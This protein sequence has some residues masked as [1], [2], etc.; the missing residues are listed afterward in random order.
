MSIRSG[1]QALAAVALALTAVAC[2]LTGTPTAAPVPSTEAPPEAA[3]PTAMVISTPAAEPLVVTHDGS[4]FQIYGLDGS[5]RE[6][7][8]AEGLSYARPNTAQVIG[9]AIYYVAGGGGV[10]GEIVRRVT[11]G[12]T[13]DLEFT[14]S[15][16]PSGLAF[17]VSADGGRIAWSQTNWASGPPF[18]QLWMAGIDG[19]NPVLVAQT[20]AADDIAEFFVL[21][22]VLWLDDGDLVYAWQVSGIGGYILYFGW[23]SLY[24][25]EA[26]GAVTT[27]LA[28]VEPDVTAPCW[29]DVTP[30]G[31]FALGAC[32]DAH[33]IVERDTASGLET[34]FPPLPE[35]G[36]AGAAEYAPSPGRLAYGIARGDPD[37]EAGQLVLVGGPG[38]GPTPL[39]AVAPGAFS[40]IEWIDEA[41]LVA[42][43]WLGEGP[44][45]S[46]VD[47]IGIDGSRRP[48]GPGSLIGL[49]TP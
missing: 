47:L 31:G 48:I 6:S 22:P 44:A 34:V 5:L 29:T 19:S 17:A 23:S 1:P 15:E 20:D 14:R 2:S 4:S 45:Q 8:P 24:R 12:E 13:V 33:A 40:R 41:R 36:Q 30:D 35:Q 16:A 28:G 39:A 38:V 25:Y 9:A 49:M 42:D 37:N 18:S 43:Y 26:A 7:R 46:S 11:A 21:E 3:T 32:G 10:P 27:P